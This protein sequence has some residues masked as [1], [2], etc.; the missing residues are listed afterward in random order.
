MIGE[1]NKI[2][3]KGTKI[4]EFIK[5]SI[6]NMGK[7]Y[8]YLLIADKSIDM[9]LWKLGYNSK[10]HFYTWKGKGIKELRA[11]GDF[12][13]IIKVEDRRIHGLRADN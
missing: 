13:R 3:P 9:E 5:G 6:Q 12:Q 7:D 11:K 10:W 4:L 2:L 8:S 1:I